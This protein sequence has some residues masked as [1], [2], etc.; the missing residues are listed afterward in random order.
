MSELK[1][2]SGE[3][4][5]GGGPAEPQDAHVGPKAVELGLIT[6][7]RLSEV[8]QQLSTARPAVPNPSSSLGAALVS[9]G[10][11]THRQVEVLVEGGGAAPTR[12]GK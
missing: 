9:R 11:L 12:V 7:N 5:R 8:L 6:A 2:G 4:S 10:C 1:M 3:P